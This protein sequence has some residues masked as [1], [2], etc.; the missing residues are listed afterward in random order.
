[1]QNPRHRCSYFQ[2]SH[3]SARSNNVKREVAPQVQSAWPDCRCRQQPTQFY[4]RGISVAAPVKSS[5][6]TVKQVPPVALIH[7]GC[8]RQ[9]TTCMLLVPYRLINLLHSF[10]W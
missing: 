3:T 7:R 6:L 5:T 10:C 1:M 2:E 8:R 9:I 4:V